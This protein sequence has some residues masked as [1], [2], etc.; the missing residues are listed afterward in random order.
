MTILEEATPWNMM[1]V[2]ASGFAGVLLSPVHLCLLLSN[3]YFGARLSGV[4]IYLIPATLAI[5]AAGFTGYM[6]SG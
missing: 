1:F 3:Q 6:V 5:I 4:Y 2:F